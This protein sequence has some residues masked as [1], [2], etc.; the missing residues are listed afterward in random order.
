MTKLLIKNGLII[1]GTGKE[2]FK[3]DIA[4]E[5]D[6]IVNIG[7]IK[8]ESF[9]KVIDA[10]G[11]IVAPGFIDTHSHSSMLLFKDAFLSPKIC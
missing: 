4:I 1:D 6:I 3:G 11:K 8:D 10:N 5:N 7:K 9:D 2:R